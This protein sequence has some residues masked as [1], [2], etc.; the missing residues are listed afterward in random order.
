[1]TKRRLMIGGLALVAALGL[2]RWISGGG[3]AEPSDPDLVLDRIWVD[4]LATRPKD[5]MNVFVAIT[6]Q[7]VGIF[8]STTQWKGSYE[9]FQYTASG[10]HL[11]IVYPQTGETEK[12]KVR[13]WRCKQGEM[14]YCLELRGASRGVKRYQSQRG[15]EIGGLARPEQILDRIASVVPRAN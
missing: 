15:W 10:D 9:I 12:V 14:D 2:V 3:D 7:P 6:Q 8:Q 1:M 13:A 5:V 11:R 4:Q